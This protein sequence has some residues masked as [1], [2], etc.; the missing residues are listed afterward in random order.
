MD[1]ETV[2]Y[3]G[4]KL[5]MRWKHTYHMFFVAQSTLASLGIPWH[6]LASLRDTAGGF[7]YPE[8]QPNHG[9]GKASTNISWLLD[10]SMILRD[11]TVCFI[12][13]HNVH[14]HVWVP[15][16][17]FCQLYLGYLGWWLWL[18][19]MFV[20]GGWNHQG[21]SKLLKW[22]CHES[23]RVGFLM[24]IKSAAC[25][26]MPSD[27]SGLMH[28]INMTVWHLSKNGV[29]FNLATLSTELSR[30]WSTFY[31]VISCPMYT[32]EF[33]TPVFSSSWDA[34]F[35]MLAICSHSC[36]LEPQSML[37][38]GVY[39]K[40]E[41]KCFQYIW[42][43][44]PVVC[45]FFPVKKSIDHPSCKDPTDCR[46]PQKKLKIPKIVR[47]WSQKHLQMR[48]WSQKHL[49]M[50]NWS[51]KHLQMRNWSQKHLQVRTRPG[52][53]CHLESGHVH[54]PFPTETCPPCPKPW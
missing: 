44:T 51:Q 32:R 35:S 18:I 4:F 47:K 45:F 2:V 7:K 22:Y 37:S 28:W 9:N 46:M 3:H 24:V 13:F 52:S 30:A 40:F 17:I 42:P 27:W 10:D 8:R 26:A 33:Q 39:G 31:I 11:S 38:I 48:K 25:F 54:N 43:E 15:E 34:G 29:T 53:S 5:K 21:K 6:P 41:R 23:P 14:C 20:L 12:I 19:F 1:S 36:W 16:G 50:R 49:Q